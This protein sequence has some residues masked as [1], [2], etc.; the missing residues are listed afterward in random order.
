MYWALRTANQ[1]VFVCSHF[2][3]LQDAMKALTFTPMNAF[4][5]VHQVRALGFVV[6]PGGGGDG[7]ETVRQS[8][9]TYAHDHIA[10]GVHRCEG[11]CLHGILQDARHVLVDVVDEVCGS[12]EYPD[13][14]EEILK[15]PPGPCAAT[16]PHVVFDA[17]NALGLQQHQQNYMLS[18]KRLLYHLPQLVPSS[19][20][21]SCQLRQ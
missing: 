17:S 15:E 6:E 5:N 8:H 11:R 13:D 21:N 10:E 1:R 18:T 4:I 19:L 9:Q 12:Q 14:Q 2:L 16:R 3:V 20:C 7:G